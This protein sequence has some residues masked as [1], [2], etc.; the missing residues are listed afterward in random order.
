MTRK[1]G[2]LMKSHKDVR[3]AIFAHFPN[4]LVTSKHIVHMQAASFS[5][6]NESYARLL[7]SFYT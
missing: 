1:S 7:R 3:T 5:Y 2:G 6:Y 4:D